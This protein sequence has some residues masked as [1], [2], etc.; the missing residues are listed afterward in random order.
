MF[1]FWAMENMLFQ[2]ITNN[3]FL[4]VLATPL[5]NI[6]VGRVLLILAPYFEYNLGFLTNR[7]KT[8]TEARVL[9][10]ISTIQRKV[11]TVKAVDP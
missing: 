5:M 9:N 8:V 11:L 2:D 6:I 3:T 4:I 7:V 10:L 1:C